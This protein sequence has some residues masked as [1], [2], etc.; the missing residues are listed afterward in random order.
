MCMKREHSISMKVNGLTQQADKPKPHSLYFPV[1]YYYFLF[2]F[3]YSN[4]ANT[5][6]NTANTYSN[7]ANTYSN[8]ANTYSNTANT[9]SNTANTYSNTANT[10]SNTAYD[11]L[12]PGGHRLPGSPLNVS[13]KLD[14]GYT[15]H[16]PNR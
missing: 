12:M 11:I 2:V 15:C 13:P 10:Y 4:T 6:S 9:Y 1:F 3:S 14:W 7:T 8:T 16:A 5:Y